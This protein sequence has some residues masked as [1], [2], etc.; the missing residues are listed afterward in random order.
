MSHG[1]ITGA[2]RTHDPVVVSTESRVG[3]ARCSGF[4][5]THDSRAD[6]AWILTT[7][8]A[9]AYRHVVMSDDAIR[10]SGERSTTDMWRDILMGTDPSL[11]ALRRRFRRLPSEPRCKLCAAPFRG[12]GRLLTKLMMHGPSAS[13]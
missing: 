2:R 5:V 8:A 1:C 11:P 12:P 4:L 9:K 10:P 3:Q 6:V 13:N 7:V